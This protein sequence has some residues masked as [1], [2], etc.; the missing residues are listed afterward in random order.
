MN[1]SASFYPMKK[2]LTLRSQLPI[3]RVLRGEMPD[4]VEMFLSNPSTMQQGMYLNVSARPLYDAQGTLIGGV[5]VS[6]DV[7]ELKQTERR[8]K[9]TIAQLEDQAQLMQSV[10]N[11]ISDGVVG[12]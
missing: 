5:S 7:T 9:E 1:E 8:L 12:R 3:A 6:R 11:S 4:H 2:R 10:F